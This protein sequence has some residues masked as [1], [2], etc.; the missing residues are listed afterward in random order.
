MACQQ[1]FLLRRRAVAPLGLWDE[2]ERQRESSV[3]RSD[4]R[5]TA[6]ICE[7]E[8]PAFSLDGAGHPSIA[9]LLSDL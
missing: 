7:E 2:L 6:A 9:R 1:R 8:T 4:Q 5:A 3:G